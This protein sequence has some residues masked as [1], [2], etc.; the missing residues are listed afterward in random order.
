LGRLFDGVHPRTGESLGEP[1]RVRD[2]ADRVTGWDLTF[3]A[4]KS[5]SALWATVG[6][7][8]GMEVRDAHDAA[9]ATALDHLEDHAAFSRQGKA[10]VRQVDSEGLLAAAFV[11]RSSRAG[12]PQLHT[13]V[14]VSG[15][16]RCAD[17]VWRAL[18]SRALHRE[19]K[20]AGMVYQAGLRVEL[21]NRLG[22]AWTPV[23]RHGQAEV[24]GVPGDLRA[25]FSKRAT[26]VE[27]RAW[28][29]IAE[30]EAKLGRELSPKGRRRIYEV[31]V[32]ETRTAKQRGGEL[33]EGLFD[34]WRSE[35][36]AAGCEPR[37]VGRGGTGPQDVAPPRAVGC[38]W[39]GA[40]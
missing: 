1:Y 19:L 17:G 39:R 23:D 12:D 25:L 21:A 8:V 22:V 34:R 18:D 11:H 38:R 5:V 3:S 10:G 13:H 9:V 15:R 32:L 30:A 28:E 4:P 26:A 31:A 37:A 6:G 36:I 27:G 24:V 33:D 20:T 14:L 7:E 35:A 16:V 40:R 29:L 2:G